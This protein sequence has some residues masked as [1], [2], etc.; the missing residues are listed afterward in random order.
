MILEQVGSPLVGL[1]SHEAVEILEAQSR[2]PLVERT[3]HAVLI[4]RSVVVLPKPGGRITIILENI[5]NG[6]VLYSDDRVVA[7]KAGGEFADYARPDRVMV[8]AGNQRRARGRAKRGGMELR[9]TQPGLCHAIHSGRRDDAAES[10][11]DAIALVVGHDEED[12]RRPFRRYHA[13]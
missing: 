10:T 5:A 4:G 11:R 13:W 9:V 7:G 1:A 12:I 6:G 3:G 8:A 2:G